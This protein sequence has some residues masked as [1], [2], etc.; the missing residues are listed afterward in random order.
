MITIKYVWR[1]GCSF[2]EGYLP[3]WQEF[4][5]IA[6]K[7]EG[8]KCETVSITRTAKDNEEPVKSLNNQ[9]VDPIIDTKPALIFYSI[10]DPNSQYL[11]ITR[12][13]T[14]K[15]MC[16]ALYIIKHITSIKAQ[17]G[18]NHNCCLNKYT[19]NG[20]KVNFIDIKTIK[21]NRRSEINNRETNGKLTFIKFDVK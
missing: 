18:G 15:N 17:S 1:K 9:T 6:S 10:H 8:V 4:T 5:T 12:P 16:K 11:F 13:L 19:I 14:T 20:S 7:C 3:K 2:S 21:Q